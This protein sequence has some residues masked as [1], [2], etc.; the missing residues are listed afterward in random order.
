MSV[1][2][3]QEAPDFTLKSHTG[4]DVTLSQFRGQKNVVLVFIP[5]AFTGVCQ[6]ELCAIRDDF[7]P[8]EAAGAQILAISTDPSPSQKM[9]ADEQGY[10]FPL[11]SDFWPHGAVAKQYGAFNEERGCANRVTVV[12]GKDGKVVDRFQSGG[13][14][15]ARPADRY[16]EAMAKL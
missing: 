9:W 3:G 2:I 6:G 14:G 15:E 1:E 8:F 5:F 10:T 16:T 12:I 13:L 7:T 4:E 11:L